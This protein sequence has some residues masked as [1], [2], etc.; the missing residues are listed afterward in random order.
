MTYLLQ[1]VASGRH[2]QNFASVSSSI[3]WEQQ[4][5]PTNSHIAKL[6]RLHVNEGHGTPGCLGEQKAEEMVKKMIE[7]PN[8]RE[9]IHCD[10]KAPPIQ[11]AGI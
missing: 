7:L 4:Q 10:Q 2:L 3:Q 1:N 5:H 11:D 6:K 9:P 8:E